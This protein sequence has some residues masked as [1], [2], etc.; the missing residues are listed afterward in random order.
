[1]SGNVP[2]KEQAAVIT[3]PEKKVCVCAEAGSGKTSVLAGRYKFL[4]NQKGIDPRRMAC[5]TFTRAAAMEMKARLGENA[6]GSH[7]STFHVL[8]KDL[9]KRMPEYQNKPLKVLTD[10]HLETIMPFDS[11]GQLSKK[12]LI[13]LIHGAKESLLTSTSDLTVYCKN[14]PRLAERQKFFQQVFTLYENKMKELNAQGFFDIP[15]LICI[16]TRKMEEDEN[17]RRYAQSLYDGILVDEFQDVNTMQATMLSLMCSERTDVLIVGDDDQSIYAWRGAVQMMLQRQAAKWNAPIM[18][19]SQNFRCTQPIVDVGECFVKE[20]IGRIEKEMNAA[21][22][23]GVKPYL[24]ASKSEYEEIKGI[25]KLVKFWGDARVKAGMPEN[26]RY[27]NEIAVLAR[28]NA[29][30]EKIRLALKRAGVPT[31]SPSGN[32][33]VA[34]KCDAIIKWALGEADERLFLTFSKDP[35]CKEVLKSLKNPYTVREDMEEANLKASVPSERIKNLLKIKKSTDFCVLAEAFKKIGFFS[36]EE[37]KALDFITASCKGLDLNVIYRKLENVLVSGDK[38]GQKEKGNFVTVS[39]IHGVKGLEYKNVIVDMTYGVFGQKNQ[40]L[41]EEELRLAYVATTRAR[42][43]LVYTADMSQGISPILTENVPA[44]LVDGLEPYVTERAE[45]DFS[46]SVENTSKEMDFSQ[47]LWNPYVRVNDQRPVYFYTGESL[48]HSEMIPLNY[49]ANDKK[50]SIQSLHE[51][52]AKEFHSAKVLEI[53]TKSDNKLGKA[54][55]AFNLQVTLKDGR[56]VPLE[57]AFQASKVF[58]KTGSRPNLLNMR[59][60]DAKYRAGQIKEP[61]VGFELDGERFDNEPVTFFYNWLYVNALKDNPQYAKELV[62]YNAFTDIEFNP[63]KSKNCQAEAA[64]VY[65]GLAKEGLLERALSSK[66]E[67]KKIVYENEGRKV[68]E[69]KRIALGKV[70]SEI[71]DKTKNKGVTDTFGTT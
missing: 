60:Y 45:F 23:T 9:M 70:F 26:L 11:S 71:E 12:D 62:N 2:T 36:V 35:V 8:G 34:D 33:Q 44:N 16:P 61:I 28:T 25:V 68:A 66:E 13:A 18:H 59:P 38:G 20:N 27:A 24:V 51:H 46:N 4:T 30:V 47:A 6:K 64:S 17:F 32:T 10:R 56:K 1:M 48:T 65:V 43:N 19:L 21:N 3:S 67:F 15:D 29:M 14:K 69:E 57:S 22:A 5:V 54:L 50:T 40:V 63:E 52:F 41:G 49:N 39:T 7:I 58:E 42:R 53:S 55:S 31:C 37:E